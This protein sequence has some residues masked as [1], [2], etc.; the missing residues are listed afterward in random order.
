MSRRKTFFSVPH[1]EQSPRFVQLKV[2]YT[3][4][5]TSSTEPRLSGRLYSA[6]PR[7]FYFIFP[8]LIEFLPRPAETLSSS[9]AGK[10]STCSCSPFLSHPS[11]PSPFPT[12]TRTFR[13]P[14]GLFVRGFPRCISSLTTR[15]RD[16]E[17]AIARRVII[18]ADVTTGPV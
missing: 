18:F 14:S 8:P 4:A 5:V 9:R 1:S 11:C 6:A 17:L 7:V 16:D 2:W 15:Y 13:F 10:G 3:Y 12:L